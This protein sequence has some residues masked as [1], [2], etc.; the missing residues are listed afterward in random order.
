MIR[1]NPLLV[2]VA[3]GLGGAGP[4]QYCYLFCLLFQAVVLLIW[5]PH[6]SLFEVLRGAHH[7]D[8]LLAVLV[9]A[10]A[11][12]AYYSVCAGG[13]EF[14]LSGQR[15]LR[16]WIT[17]SA[18]PVARITAGYVVG[19]LLQSSHAMVLSLPLILVAYAVGGGEMLL[20]AWVIALALIQALCY[21]LAAAAIY[22]AVGHIGPLTFLVLRAILLG[23]YLGGATLA[24][25]VSHLAVSRQLLHAEQS[26]EVAL[27]DAAWGSAQTIANDA[28]V[29]AWAIVDWLG[30]SPTAVFFCT[31]AIAALLLI[32][33]FHAQLNTHRRRTQTPVG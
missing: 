31:Y 15:P 7:P 16:E 10:G 29:G 26:V 19:H 32:L 5:W 24:P 8:T 17:F 27:S 13:E 28:V 23:G 18:L 4:A 21:R 12:L 33:V 9:A 22:L 11:S 3:R 30:L 20:V 25:F 2:E 1:A 6:E 14:L